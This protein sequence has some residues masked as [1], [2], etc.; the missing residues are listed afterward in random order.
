MRLMAAGQRADRLDTDIG[1]EDEEG[2][3]DQLLGSSLRR[4]RAKARAGEQPQDDKT[5]DRLD[6]RVG[7]EADQG[8]RARGKTGADGDRGLKNVVAN[9]APRQPARLMLEPS[10]LDERIADRRRMRRCEL[11][12]L[13]A[14][15][16]A[17]IGACE[18]SVASSTPSSSSTPTS[19]SE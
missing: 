16:A 15:R 14:Q 7:A 2:N 5:R 13:V 18:A 3:G 10:P 1:C 11:D 4:V 6:Q 8:D 19:L 9:A 12:Q 17:S